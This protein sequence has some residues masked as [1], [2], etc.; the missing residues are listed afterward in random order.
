M[1]VNTGTADQSLP[2]IALIVLIKGERMGTSFSV[3]DKPES[4]IILE[5]QPLSADQWPRFEQMAVGFVCLL[6]RMKSMLFRCSYSFT[7]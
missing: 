2:Q 3:V 5:S 7:A 6:Q 4:D 1:C